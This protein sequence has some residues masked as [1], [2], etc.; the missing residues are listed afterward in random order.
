MKI[1]IVTPSLDLKKPFSAT[2]FLLQL[3]KGFADEGHELLIIPYVGKEISSLWWKAYPNPNYRKSEILEKFLRKNKFSTK[4]RK[5]PFIPQLARFLAKPNLEKLI[6]KI[7]T[8]EKNIDAV[9]FISIPLNQIGGIAN[10]IKK[11]SKIPIIYYDLDVPTSLPSQQGFAYGFNYFKGA[12]ID[13]YDIFVTLSEGSTSEMYEL[14]ASDVKVVHIGVDPTILSPASFKKDNDFFFLGAGSDDRSNNIRM[15]ITNPSNILHKKFLVSGRRFST[16]FG[17]AKVIPMVSFHEMTILCNKAKIN[18]NVVRE[19]HALTDSTSTA[20]P[21]ELASLGCC[22]VS[23]PY[24]GLEKWFD[25]K[26]EI[27]ITNSSKESLEIYKMLLDNSELRNKM[28][29]AA[30]EKI[31]LKHTSRHRA[32]EFIEIIKKK[33][34]KV[35]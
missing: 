29:I 7:I 8:E 11:I 33:S 1:I 22:I 10:N 18:L 34:S 23:S 6:K 13:E 27:L 4:K 16:D 2:P 31:L 19:L 32:R 12:K 28:G 25:L 9:M 21:F 5:L 15:M 24:K 30:R 17:Q 14:G 20:R 35:G 26:K 3:F